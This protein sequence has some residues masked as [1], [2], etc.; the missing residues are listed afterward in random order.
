VGG[1]GRD[2]ITKLATTVYGDPTATT[3]EKQLARAWLLY[4]HG[5]LPK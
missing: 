1:K 3:R 5:K 4:I 2:M